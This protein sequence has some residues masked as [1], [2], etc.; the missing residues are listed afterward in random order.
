M[1][2]VIR[3]TEND[4]SRIVR[5]VMSEMEDTTSDVEEVLDSN[6]RYQ[7]AFDELVDILQ[8][9]PKIKRRVQSM[10]SEP[11][12]E[13]YEYMDYYDSKPK[14]IS[15]K[16]YWMEKLVSVGIP[17]AIAA[18]IGAA[19]SHTG[20]GTDMLEMALAAAAGGA[21]IGATIISQTGR[22]KVD[23]EPEYDDENEM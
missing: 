16:S 5:R 12:N 13:K 7:T 22:K 11:L 23:D 10:V 19:I 4:L 6:P 14:K 1:K 17:A 18:T 20:G 15:R 21:G 3:L 8:S 9:N 2:K